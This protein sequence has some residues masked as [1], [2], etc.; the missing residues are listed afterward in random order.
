MLLHS[1]QGGQGSASWGTG[2]QL[3]KELEWGRSW[4][5]PKGSQSLEREELGK[6][7]PKGV[8]WAPASP[9]PSPEAELAPLE[10]GHGN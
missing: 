1:L 10:R 5:E 4:A 3:R 2:P 7:G 8:A 9:S 6:G